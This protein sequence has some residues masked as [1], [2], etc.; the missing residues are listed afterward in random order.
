MT[1]KSR[2]GTVKRRIPRSRKSAK[3]SS[4]KKSGPARKTANSARKSAGVRRR[5]SR[6]RPQRANASMNMTEL[7]VIA[8]SRGIPF[9]GLT[10]TKL[11][12]KI[13]NYY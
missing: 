6:Q 1:M 11:I 7:Q 12:R 9:G 13:N 3:G 5:I 8:K 4:R 10:K 2:S